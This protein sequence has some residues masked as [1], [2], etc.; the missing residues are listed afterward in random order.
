M[1]LDHSAQRVSSFDTNFNCLWL[2]YRLFWPPWHQHA[3]W[4]RCCTNDR[5]HL[6]TACSLHRPNVSSANSVPILRFPRTVRGQSKHALPAGQQPTVSGARGRAARV[7][8][9]IDIAAAAE[10]EPHE[11]LLLDPTSKYRH[12]SHR[13]A[14]SSVF[15]LTPRF[16]RP[17]KR[18][19]E[20]ERNW[21]YLTGFS[22]CSW[23]R[24]FL[25]T[26]RF[27]VLP[28]I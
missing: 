20:R 11:N 10:Y 21:P 19:R 22:W 23:A 9:T 2:I 3:I 17:R 14:Q 27:V 28:W 24:G 4:R 13:Y 18:E 8:W 1:K 25:F 7:T 6:V 12:R 15:Q 16:R 5:C 26:V